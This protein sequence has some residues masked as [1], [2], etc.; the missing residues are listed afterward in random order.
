MSL[1]TLVAPDEIKKCVLVVDDEIESRYLLAENLRASG[2]TVYEASSAD[3][4]VVLLRSRA[5]F[6][7]VITDIQMP[8]QMDGLMLAESIRENLPVVLV[9]VVSG[10]DMDDALRQKGTKFFQKP[11]SSQS[12]VDY[13]K[14]NLKTR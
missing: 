3:E 12:L 7:A 13:V 11:Y 9:V 10:L 4:A 14:S 2:F 5:A 1:Q 6:D 8:G